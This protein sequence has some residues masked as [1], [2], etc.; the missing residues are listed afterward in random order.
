[1]NK[2]KKKNMNLYKFSLA[3][4]LG[5]ATLTS[6]SDKLELTNPND[7]TTGTFGKSTKDLEDAVKACYHHMRME[8]TYARVGYTMD[9]CRG[10]EVYN[11]AQSWEMI[12][13][14]VCGFGVTGIIPLIFVTLSSLVA[15][16]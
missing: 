9:I 2:V 3:I 14:V 10:D 5:A 11:P 6:C 1:M 7:P 15:M 13:S 16:R 8:G 4:M 12:R